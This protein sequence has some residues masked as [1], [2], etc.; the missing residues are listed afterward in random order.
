MPEVGIKPARK[1]KKQAVTLWHKPPN[2][3]FT[4]D[5]TFGFVGVAAEKKAEKERKK[6]KENDYLKEQLKQFRKENR[7]QKKN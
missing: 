2:P 3:E 4:S 1:K 6:A 7:K 5:D